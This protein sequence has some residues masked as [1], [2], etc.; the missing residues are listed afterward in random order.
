MIKTWTGANFPVP[1]RSFLITD[2]WWLSM[3]KRAPKNL[4][5]DFD[6]MVM[7]VHWRIWKEHNSRVFDSL[8]H[9]VDDVR[10]LEPSVRRVE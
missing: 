2:Q 4:L 10:T 1:D 7:L 3:R 8:R 5:R 9:S 6:A